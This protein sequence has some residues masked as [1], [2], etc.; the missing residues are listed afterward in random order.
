MRKL[1]P[2]SLASVIKVILDITFYLAIFAGVLL[3]VITVAIPLVASKH[4]TQNPEV[5][6]ELDPAVY[7]ISSE[8]LGIEE[9]PIHE[10]RGKIEIQ[11]VSNKRMLVSLGFAYVL[12]A[13]VVLVLAKLRE[14][15]QTLKA[16]NPFVP[17]NAGR[18]RFIGLAVI[19]GEFARAAI[20]FGYAVDVAWYF[21]TI[22]LT[23]RPDFEPNVLVILLGLIVLVLSE[24]F[25]LGTLMQ[26][27]QQLTV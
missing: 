14:I 12:L 4:L 9:A 15:F 23:I 13:V 3:V 16:A 24:V 1:G 21:R 19:F 27:E 11:G 2:K 6:F 17:A 25:R 10:A 18:I 22:V 7:E 26:E 5:F 8:S 20:E